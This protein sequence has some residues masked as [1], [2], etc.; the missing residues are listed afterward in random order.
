MTFSPFA[1]TLCSSR[2]TESFPVLKT[3][4]DIFGA[5]LLSTAF[6]CETISIIPK[7]FTR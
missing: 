3:F 4:F 1:K 5:V 7:G 6:M 2:F